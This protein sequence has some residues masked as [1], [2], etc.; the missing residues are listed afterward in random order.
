MTMLTTLSGGH[1]DGSAPTITPAGAS[2][3]RLMML[4]VSILPLV[5]L[6]GGYV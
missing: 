6:L 1:G 5:I 4:G 3:P 2:M